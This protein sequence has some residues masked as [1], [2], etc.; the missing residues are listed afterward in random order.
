VRLKT[1]AETQHGLDLLKTQLD[2]VLADIRKKEVGSMNEIL[3][4]GNKVPIRNESVRM[5]ILSADS[6]LKFELLQAVSVEQKVQ[7]YDKV[8]IHYNDAHRQISS[9][10]NSA[11]NSKKPASDIKNLEELKEFITY[12]KIDK[13]L[14][15]NLML[16]ESLE[17]RFENESEPD[18]PKADEIV[19]LYE[20]LNDNITELNNFG[21][22]SDKSIKD[23]AAQLLTYKSFRCLYL[24]L[25][26]FKIAKWPEA[27]A[28]FSHCQQQIG[29]AIDHHKECDIKNLVMIEKL[30]T[31]LS[32]AQALESRAHAQGFLEIMQQRKTETEAAS[33]STSIEVQTPEIPLEERTLEPMPC[34]P[35]LFDLAVLSCKYPDLKSRLPTKRW[36]WF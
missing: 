10:I 13:T 36:G 28:L 7:L 27:K 11:K 34:K 8:F 29:E 30:N 12:S 35:L 17:D 4:K 3:W 32:K 9:D 23:F 14:Q 6:I 20:I 33:K 31:A 24:G 22:N 2:G 21:D 15:R 19:R 16:V 25:T 26:Y 5:S 18:Q 1:Q